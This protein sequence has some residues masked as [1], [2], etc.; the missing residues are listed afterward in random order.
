MG[1]SWEQ[2]RALTPD[3]PRLD[4]AAALAARCEQALQGTRW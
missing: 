2:V 3:G 4:E 1:D